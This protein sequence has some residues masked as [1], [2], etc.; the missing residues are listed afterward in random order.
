[1]IQEREKIAIDAYLALMKSK[2]ADAAMLEKRAEFLTILA[3]HLADKQVNGVDYR[4]AVE[5]AM[6]QVQADD[7]HASL[8]VSR[9]YFIFWAQDIK[10]IA[11]YSRTPIFNVK[12]IE[13]KPEP[14][15]LKALT[16]SLETEKLEVSESW[17]LKAYIQALRFEGAE[18]PL[19]DT[20]VKLVKIMLI[21]VRGAPEHDQKYYR[22][23]ID[24]TLPLFKNKDSRRLFL[25]VVREFY[26]FWIGNPDAASMVLQDGSGNMLI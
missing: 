21:R 23:A 18:Q 9:E 19:V 15:T 22:M 20:R 14:T 17:P 10:S 25:I 26:H 16:D 4:E 7:W 5:H 2:G 12:P 3:P 24:L 1:M 11:A 8:S 13:W 6:E